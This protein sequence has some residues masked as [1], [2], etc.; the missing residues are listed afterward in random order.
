MHI[1]FGEA[2]AVKTLYFIERCKAQTI[3]KGMS[4][5][6]YTYQTQ[7]MYA[8]ETAWMDVVGVRVAQLKGQL[9]K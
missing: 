5:F 9:C 6:N 8:H 4:E 2:T 1:F 3:L 7:N